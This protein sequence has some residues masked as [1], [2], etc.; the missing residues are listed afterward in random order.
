MGNTKTK[1]TKILP[2][3]LIMVLPAILLI[4]YLYQPNETANLKTTALLIILPL[5]YLLVWH[6]ITKASRV[7]LWI[8]SLNSLARTTLLV[9]MVITSALVTSLVY[10]TLIELIAENITQIKIYS[11][12]PWNIP[13]LIFFVLS[14]L[15]I[16]FRVLLAHLLLLII[17]HKAYLRCALW[18]F[19]LVAL[20]IVILDPMLLETG[21]ASLLCF[22]AITI[23][24][25][26][27]KRSGLRKLYL[28]KLIIITLNI[29]LIVVVCYRA[30]QFKELENCT[31]SFKTHCTQTTNTPPQF[32]T[33]AIVQ[34]DSI[35]MVNAQIIDSAELLK[36]AQKHR[37]ELQK[38]PHN[39]IFIL[40]Q[41]SLLHCLAL[42]EFDQATIIS[43]TKKLTLVEIIL[44]WG[45]AIMIISLISLLI[46]QGCSVDII[47]ALTKRARAETPMLSEK[48]F[49]KISLK[50]SL[51][52]NRRLG[53]IVVKYNKLVDYYEN[54]CQDIAKYER[55]ATWREMAKQVAHEIRNPLTPMRLKIEMLQ[56]Y[57]GGDT[58]QYLRRVESTLE[59]LLEQIDLLSNIADGFTD[60]SRIPDSKLQRFNLASL[61]TSVVELYRDR[62]AMVIE[63][64][65]EQKNSCYALINHD[66]MLRV[67]INLLKNSYE[68][69][70]ETEN[71]E[72]RVEIN[73]YSEHQE[74]VIELQNNSPNI[75]NEVLDKIFE[76]N[77]STKKRGSGVGLAICRGVI[78]SFDGTITAQNIEPT[79]VAFIIKIPQHRAE[80]ESTL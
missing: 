10:F 41:N 57:K 74:V 67:M 34:G 53:G 23:I 42:R 12:T 44:F 16:A 4:Y 22:A 48:E 54:N 28:S 19:I 29:T 47:N 25:I 31:K 33:C 80:Q 1:T 13:T 60:M 26:H 15:I 30:A 45:Y 79:G 64:N 68:A 3:V 72:C 20:L 6:L 17:P 36:L 61:L 56:H 70:N 73:L 21:I 39:Q 78:E 9:S 5:L 58:Q 35:E 38:L 75:E 46:L 69:I 62:P 66:A 63:L 50:E 65:I 37:K 18:G 43:S 8:N 76:L 14:A 49:S 77:F 11:P 24:F 7:K 71:K 32:I 40:N 55:D 27:T 2:I 52:L 59:V 51:K